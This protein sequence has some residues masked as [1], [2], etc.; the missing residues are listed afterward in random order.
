M[1]NRLAGTLYLLLT[2]VIWGGSF[3]AQSAGMD[4]IGPFTFQA[5]RCFLAVLVLLAITAIADC[6]TPGKFQKKWSD[7]KLWKAG[8]LCGLVLFAST[9]LQ[10][11]ALAMNTGAGKAGFITALY[12]VFVPI[13]SILRKR[14]PTVTALISV[15]IALCGMYLLCGSDLTALQLG[16]ILLIC[17][18]VA[19][20]IQIVLVDIYAQGA[21]PLRLNCI[22]AL[23]IAVLTSFLAFLFEK[24][25]IGHITNSWLSLTYAGVFSM[26]IAY[27]LQ[28]VG[29]QRLD[30]TP[31][32]LIMSLESV[33]AALFG[34]L[35]LNETMTGT[36][37][38]GCGLMFSAVILSQLHFPQRK[39]CSC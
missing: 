11:A 22:Q 7:P 32:A 8:L 10:Q 39:K 33:F 1:K 5:V 4:H 27:S 29:Q 24:P 14:K 9:N 35:I 6:K 34:A 16:D 30:S 20:A 25:E 3:V 19:F 17:G 12:I 26:G 28:I 37:L 15:P 21:D 2:T 36:E 38:L 18:A 31:A 23:V 13:L